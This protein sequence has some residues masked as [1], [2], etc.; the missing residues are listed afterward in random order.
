MPGIA[1]APFASAAEVTIRSPL[2]IKSSLCF[3]VLYEPGGPIHPMDLCA[4]REGAALRSTGPA[5][6]CGWTVI[7]HFFTGYSAFTHR[8]TEHGCLRAGLQ[9]TRNDIT[10]TTPTR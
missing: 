9:S 5:A 2:Y 7:G 3:L 6:H 4:E 10:K 8:T 1:I